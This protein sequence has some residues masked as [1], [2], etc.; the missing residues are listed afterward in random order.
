MQIRKYTL[1]LCTQNDI[2]LLQLS[3]NDWSVLTIEIFSH[4]QLARPTSEKYQVVINLSK[5]STVTCWFL[6]FIYRFFKPKPCS[7]NCLCILQKTQKL[8]ELFHLWFRVRIIKVVS[9]STYSNETQSTLVPS[10]SRTG[11]FTHADSFDI[12][13]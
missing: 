12:P 13:S 4:A 8:S 5:F 10:R 9:Y 7:L 11:V 3:F 6:L 1:Q 2:I